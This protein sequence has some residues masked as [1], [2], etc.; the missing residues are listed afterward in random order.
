MSDPRTD[1]TDDAR[2]GEGTPREVLAT[3]VAGFAMAVSLLGAIGFAAAYFGLEDSGWQTQGLGLGLMLGLGG[4]GVGLVVWAQG[5]MPQGPHVQYRED[6][7]M[8]ST[9]VPEHVA[10]TLRDDTGQVG[11]RSLLGRMLGVALAAVGLSSLMPLLSLGPT[12]QGVSDD[13]PPTGWG[14]GRRLISRNGDPVRRDDV[15]LGSAIAVTP[16]GR[17]PSAESQVMLIRL[18]EDGAV[19]IGSGRSGWTAAGHVAYSRLCTHMG[20]AVGLY[21]VQSRALICPCHQSAFQVDDGATPQFGPATRPLPQLPLD[22]DEEGF[23]I[24]TADFDRPVGT[25]AWDHPARVEDPS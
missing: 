11:R 9:E 3:R 24:A 10:E 5:A 14:G 22:V 19:D 25:G 18:A 20:C 17:E 7:R 23:L 13:E 15:P 1:R 12:E 2:Q 6:A 4:I 16:E 8:G 21:Q